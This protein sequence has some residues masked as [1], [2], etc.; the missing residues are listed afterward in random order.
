MVSP[1]SRA[2]VRS[3]G[4]IIRDRRTAA[5]R[6]LTWL[7]HHLGMSRSA[8]NRFELGRGWPNTVDLVEGITRILAAL[9][10]QGED[11]DEIMQLAQDAGHPN[12]LAVGREGSKQFAT[13][14]EYEAIATGITSVDTSVFPGLIQTRDYAEAVFQ[15]GDMPLDVQQEHLVTR[16][17]RQNILDTAQLTVVLDESV[18]TR[19]VGTGATMRSQLDWMVA[20]AGQDNIDVRVIPNNRASLTVDGSYVLLEFS[21]QPPVAYADSALGGIFLDQ[22]DRVAHLV[23]RTTRL[24]SAAL[25]P[26]DS[27]E[28]VKHALLALDDED[29]RVRVCS[30][31]MA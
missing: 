29:G 16:L 5:D 1:H 22:E 10:V 14:L 19:Q 9:G 11:L 3:L 30:D 21:D 18:L 20:L 8:L 4:L 24:V 17:G 15:S 23:L 7:A 13:F 27:V 12:W 2:R 28:L 25:S 31:R 26:A 6:T